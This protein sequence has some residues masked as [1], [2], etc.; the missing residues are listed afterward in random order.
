MKLD[1]DIK[2]LESRKKNMEKDNQDLK[3]KI[4][5]VCEKCLKSLTGNPIFNFYSQGQG[6]R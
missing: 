1:N 5:K 3:D 2:A 6:Y 4:D